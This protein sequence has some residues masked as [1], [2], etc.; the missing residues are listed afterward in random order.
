[1]KKVTIK[2]SFDVPD[3]TPTSLCRE[4]VK[5]AVSSWRGSLQPPGCYDNSDPGDPMWHL[6]PDSVKA[7]NV[8]VKNRDR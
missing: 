4:Y 7:S 5:E 2:V 1:M 6:K 3:N 8:N